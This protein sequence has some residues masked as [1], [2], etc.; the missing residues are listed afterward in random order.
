M[1][2]IPMKEADISGYQMRLAERGKY[3][4]V[5]AKYYYFDE[6]E[7]KQVPVGSG[8]P[9]FTLRDTFTSAT[10]ARLRLRCGNRRDIRSR[11]ARQKHNPCL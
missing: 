8:S 7:E 4:K 6:A 5:I 1:P 9:A 11:R 3:G 10:Q 2:A